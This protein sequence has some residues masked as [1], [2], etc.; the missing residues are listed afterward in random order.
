MYRVCLGLP[1]IE[2]FAL[3]YPQSVNKMSM[4]GPNLYV[5]LLEKAKLCKVADKFSRIDATYQR[6]G[7]KRW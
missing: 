6:K 3:L 5:K 4:V 2:D 7:F 1:I